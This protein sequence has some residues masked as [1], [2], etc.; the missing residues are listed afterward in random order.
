MFYFRC[1]FIVAFADLTLV[2]QGLS[3]NFAMLEQ[4]AVDAVKHESGFCDA[5]FLMKGPAKPMCNSVQLFYRFRF[6]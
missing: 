5:I 3:A 1:Y 6:L 2:R 4:V